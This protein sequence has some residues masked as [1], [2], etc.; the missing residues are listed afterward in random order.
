MRRKTPIT[1][2]AWKPPPDARQPN[3]QKLDTGDGSFTSPPVQIG[4]RIWLVHTVNDGGFAR[5]RIYELS[6]TADTPLAVYQLSSVPEQNDH[7]FNASIAV[8]GAG[9]NGIAFVNAT[10][11]IRSGGKEGRA[12]MV[13]LSGPHATATGWESVVVKTSPG[14]FSL[15]N[16]GDKCN[17]GFRGAC[18]WGNLSS[19]QIDPLNKRRAWAINKLVTKGT[20]G[21]AG[22]DRN[23]S[24]MIGGV[25]RASRAGRSR[26]GI[27]RHRQGLGAWPGDKTHLRRTDARC[28]VRPFSR[29]SAS[30]RASA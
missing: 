29:S 6:T 24:I 26:L 30:S 17:D 27:P 22:S 1:I 8:N 13:V 21:G 25:K 3:G 11:T 19:I 15:D 12:A 9:A 18:A 10:R 14:Q 20:I 4:D 2:P 5:P 28:R 7:L 23:W 16:F